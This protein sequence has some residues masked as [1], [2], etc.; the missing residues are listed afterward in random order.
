MADPRADLVTKDV[1]DKHVYRKLE[2]A[3]EESCGDKHTY[4]LAVNERFP[5]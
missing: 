3:F 5:T 2:Q 4:V 1:L